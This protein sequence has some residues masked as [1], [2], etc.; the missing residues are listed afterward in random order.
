MVKNDV[1]ATGPALARRLNALSL[2]LVGGEIPRFAGVAISK[3][4]DRAESKMHRQA[5]IRAILAILD[6]DQVESVTALSEQI[7]TDCRRLQRA[8]PNIR[9][10]HR[11]PSELESLLMAWIDAGCPESSRRI[12]DCLV[13]ALGE[14]G[15]NWGKLG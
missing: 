9:S 6:P 2:R 12:R 7:A 15:A 14:T 13:A 4:I 3:G 10:G 5:L 1:L 11:Q 8:L